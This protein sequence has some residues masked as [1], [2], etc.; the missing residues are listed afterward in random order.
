MATPFDEGAATF[1]PDGKWIAY[2]SNAS[3]RTEVYLRRSTPSNEQWQI[4]TTGGENPVWSADGRELFYHSSGTIM[5]VAIRGGASPN[6]GTPAPLFRIPSGGVAPRFTGNVSRHV[7]SGVRSD[8]Q[9]FLFRLG[10]G[11]PMPSIHVVMN[12]Q[13]ALR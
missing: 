11:Q 3:M 5:H 10:S 13:K 6:A 1:S 7:I 12:W 2:Q 4:S 9:R 8:S